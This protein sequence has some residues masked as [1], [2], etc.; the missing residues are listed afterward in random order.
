[1]DEQPDDTPPATQPPAEHPPAQKPDRAP[2]PTPSQTGFRSGTLALP[3]RTRSAPQT[4][5]QR[6]TQTQT[7]TQHPPRVPQSQ[8]LPLPLSRRASP[9]EPVTTIEVKRELLED[10]P[11]GPLAHGSSG[12]SENQSQSQTLTE[13]QT[14]GGY[15]EGYGFDLGSLPLQTQRPWVMSQDS[16]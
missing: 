15:R 9:A 1:M 8:S 11:L 3:R 6:R 13:T 10:P 12:S 2:A 14:Q 7:Q 5:S 4:Q 16:Q